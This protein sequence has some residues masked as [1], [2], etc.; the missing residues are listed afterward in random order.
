MG[1]WRAF[2]QEMRSIFMLDSPAAFSAQE[3]VPRPLAQV[4]HEVTVGGAN[5]KV[6]RLEALSVPAVLRG[7]NMICNISTLPLVT[8]DENRNVVRRPFLEQIDPDVINDVTLANTL[9][10]LF[11]EGTSYWFITEFD[12]KGFPLHARHVAWGSVSLQAP[13][14]GRSPA[15]LPSGIDPRETTVYID[16]KSVP[17][18]YVIRFDSPN[19]GLLKAA[20]RPI[21]RAIQLDKVANMYAENPRPLDYITPLAGAPAMTDEE[22]HDFLSRWQSLRNKYSTGFLAEAEYHTVDAPTPADMQ[23][24]EQQAQV[25]RQLSNAIGIDPEDVGVS[26]TSRTYQN[27]VER[28]QDRIN[29]TLAP[30]LKAITSRLSMDDVT[31]PGEKVRFDLDDYLRADP[32]TRAEVDALRISN[33]T[34]TPE[35]SRKD[36]NMPEL[37]AGQ[38][39]AAPA[40]EAPAVPQTVGASRWVSVQL[41]SDENLTFA[42]VPLTTFAVDPEARTITGLAV[43]FNKIALNG[44]RRWRF[45]PGSLE[46]AELGRVKLLRDHDRAQA[47][48]KAVELTQTETGY[49][50]S[51]KVARGPDGDRVL[52]LAED[53]VLDGLSIGVEIA[54]AVPD[55]DNR[56]ALLVRRALL[57]EVS[58]TAMPAFDDSRLTSVKAT[59]DEGN[60]MSDNA[61]P[62][63]QA[64]A[65]PAAAPDLNAFFAA[66][67]A[68]QNTNR[69]QPTPEPEPQPERRVVN[70]TRSVAATFVDEAPA[71]NFHGGSFSEGKFDFATD[72]VNALKSQD[73]AAEARALEFVQAQFAV[74]TANVTDLNPTV[75][76]PDMYVDHLEYVTP[77]WDAIRKGTIDSV[78]PFRFPKFNTASGLVNDHTEG[79]E[80]TPGA[81]TATS[82]TVEPDPLSGKVEINR[83]VW[84]QGGNPQVSTLIWREMLRSWNEGLEDKAVDL[85]AANAVTGTGT[86]LTAGLANKNLDA[87]LTSLLASL[88]FRRGGF[89]LREFPVHVD[90]YKALA[91]AVDDSGRKLFPQIGPQN[92]T[93]TAST[94]WADIIV[95]GVRARPA[96]ALGATSSGYSDSYLFNRDDVHGWASAPQ[97]LQLEYQVKSIEIGIWGYFAGAVTRANE[98]LRIK[99]DPTA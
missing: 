99:Y 4:I 24:V 89:R 30:Y 6:S 54:D 36:E 23:I 95:G 98:V 84:D 75:N 58:L 72:L 1:F 79:V 91:G 46:F 56:G 22:V 76:R 12:D 62:E 11:F 5:P 67:Q 25:D 61:T 73:K 28:R 92:A 48:G 32:K 88:Q 26:T 20:A 55:P 18:D 8:V 82:Q 90:L 16:G 53:G 97:R 80:P 50:V 37:P 66:W 31:R 86:V 17:W 85:L 21:R 7:R 96:W 87:A 71:Y 83:E 3:S 59:R 74:T 93:G 94:Y 35:E 27:A 42:D 45:A 69:T 60:P 39:P 64:P 19:P 13:S 52:A 33:G 47:V 40:V 43:P 65:A 70:P 51:F 81:L 29:N 57:R 34:K 49:V 10:D 9:E 41:D 68:Q 77:V 38:R 63:P 15:P 2:G 14:N 44:G 78:T